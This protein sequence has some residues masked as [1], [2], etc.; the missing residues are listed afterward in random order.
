MQKTSILDSQDKIDSV[1]SLIDEYD[2]KYCTPW[3]NSFWG[4]V[5][6]ISEL[7]IKFRKLAACHKSTKRNGDNGRE[8]Y[9]NRIEG[10]FPIYRL[11]EETT[12]KETHEKTEEVYE[13][14]F[15]LPEMDELSKDNPFD[16]N[17]FR[18]F[19]FLKDWEFVGKKSWLH[20]CQAAYIVACNQSEHKFRIP[21]YINEHLTIDKDLYNKASILI[22][23][24][25][26]GDIERTQTDAK[27]TEEPPTVNEGISL[28]D[29]KQVVFDALQNNKPQKT[30]P[31]QAGAKPIYTQ[32]MMDRAKALYN[33][34]VL[35]PAIT[36]TIEE[37]FKIVLKE[38]S[39][40][41]WKCRP[42]PWKVSKR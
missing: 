28:E 7:D 41:G 22:E 15:D 20:I 23:A 40:R 13:C 38:N 17:I 6:E 37:E 42:K 35:K 3:V 8:T 30:E 14:R 24:L 2:K 1:Q 16:K 9:S 36:K 21:E 5:K 25:F 29:I 32:A 33:E 10:G 31:K 18:A 27:A 11:I 26:N 34:G 39:I 12:D 19:V 4:K